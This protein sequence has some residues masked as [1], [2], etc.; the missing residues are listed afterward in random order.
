MAEELLCPQCGKTVP[1]D[2][3]QGLCP[4]CVMRAA[5]ES[6]VPPEESNR[7]VGRASV[8][9][10]VGIGSGVMFLAVFVVQF[11]GSQLRA[12]KEGM[13]VGLGPM[14]LGLLVQGERPGSQNV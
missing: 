13:R 7:P 11:L 12:Q 1:A 14:M 9:F 5:F 3:P 4:T 10:T 8:V 2:A 6:K